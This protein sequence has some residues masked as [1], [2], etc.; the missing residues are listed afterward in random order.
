MFLVNLCHL[1]EP[2]LP[3]ED[4]AP[5]TFTHLCMF[6]LRRFLHL[7]RTGGV[8]HAEQHAFACDW[9]A[10][11]KALGLLGMFSVRLEC[12]WLSKTHRSCPQ[13]L[14]TEAVC[15]SVRV[16]VRVCTGL[17][18]KHLFWGSGMCYIFLAPEA[19]LVFN[20]FS[21]LYLSQTSD[22]RFAQASYSATRSKP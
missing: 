13:K 7:R 9:S 14:S 15:V 5:S 12:M 22:V 6:G 20:H 2:K 11:R 3:S 21:G 10:C 1:V 16:C 17:D 18:G 19:G 8:S 4:F